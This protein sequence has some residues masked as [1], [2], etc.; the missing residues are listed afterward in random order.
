MVYL[1]KGWD[2]N[3]P[4]KEISNCC[5]SIYGHELGT[6]VRSVS[7]LIELTSPSTDYAADKRKPLWR[8]APRN[9]EWL[10]YPVETQVLSMS[11]E[12]QQY[13][14]DVRIYK[15]ET[16]LSV[17]PGLTPG[18]GPIEQTAIFLD[19]LASERET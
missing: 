8:L 3:M 9:K 5:F 13:P 6:I 18:K 11:F 17:H 15:Q 12:G 16:R 7:K 4:I 10:R 14:I 1:E 19:S 2:N